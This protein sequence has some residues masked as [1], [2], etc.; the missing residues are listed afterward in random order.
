MYRMKLSDTLR[1][2]L[3]KKSNHIINDLTVNHYLSFGNSKNVDLKFR[4]NYFLNIRKCFEEYGDITPTELKNF[5]DKCRE[6]SEHINE[7]T[8]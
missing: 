7:L 2:K 8:G 3:I 4:L 6:C 1:R 5:D